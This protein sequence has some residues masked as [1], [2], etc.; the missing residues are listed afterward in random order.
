MFTLSVIVDKA[1]WFD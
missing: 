1:V